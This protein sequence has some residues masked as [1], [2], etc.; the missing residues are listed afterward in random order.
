M[1]IVTVFTGAVCTS[2]ETGRPRIVTQDDF[3]NYHAEGGGMYHPPMRYEIE[4]STP[5]LLL[6]QLM[7]M[8]RY[9]LDLANGRPDKAWGVIIDE[10]EVESERLG[11][12]ANPPQDGIA[13]LPTTHHF[14]AQ[15]FHTKLFPEFCRRMA[16]QDSAQCE[17]DSARYSEARARFGFPAP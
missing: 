9:L 13:R 7:L 14:L 8:T 10:M 5:P 1:T 17:A 12:I 3:P 2:R 11:W 15:A 4:G 16:H 6:G